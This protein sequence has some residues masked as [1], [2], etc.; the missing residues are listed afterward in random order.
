MNIGLGSLNSSQGNMVTFTAGNMTG[1]VSI[2]VQATYNGESVTSNVQIAITE[3][4]NIG[5]STPNAII[6]VIVLA[7]V[8]AVV[9]MAFALRRRTLVNMSEEPRA[10]VPV[11]GPASPQPER[12]PTASPEPPLEAEPKVPDMPPASPGQSQSTKKVVESPCPECHTLV[13]EGTQVCEVCGH[14]LADMW[15]DQQK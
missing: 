15:K 14:Q 13:E 10:S 5:N 9:A 6:F 11:S 12:A 3:E 8:A 1:N 2:T 7:A 4:T